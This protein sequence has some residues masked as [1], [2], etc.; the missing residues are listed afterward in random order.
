MDE[1]A[2]AQRDEHRSSIPKDAGSSPACRASVTITRHAK[3][4]MKERLGLPRSALQKAADRAF[5]EGRTHSEFNG[6][7]KRYLDSL[8]FMNKR[9]GHLRIYGGQVYIFAGT[10]L[11]TVY[12][13]P[14]KLRKVFSGPRS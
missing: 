4:R 8:W 11:V 12:P 14:Q 6:S 7:A 2:V 3:K 13:V 1:P 9:I 5:E 10:T